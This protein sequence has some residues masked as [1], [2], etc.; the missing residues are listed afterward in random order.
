MKANVSDVINAAPKASI[1]LYVLSQLC[2]YI[3]N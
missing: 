1:I 3:F 2:V